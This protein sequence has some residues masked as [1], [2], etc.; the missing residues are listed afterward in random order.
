[1]CLTAALTKTMG[2]ERDRDEQQGGRR[3]QGSCVK[4]YL[5]WKGSESCWEDLAG[6]FVLGVEDEA[7]RLWVCSAFMG[8]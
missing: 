2:A 4:F 5:L 7:Q 8:Q 3:L 6:F 1:M